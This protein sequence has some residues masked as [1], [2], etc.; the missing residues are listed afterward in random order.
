[1]ISFSLHC[2]A[3]GLLPMI[4]PQMLPILFLVFSTGNVIPFSFCIFLS[5]PF[6]TPRPIRSNA[7][8]S[9]DCFGLA[10]FWSSLDYGRYRNIYPPYSTFSV[11]LPLFP[12]RPGYLFPTTESV[13][14]LSRRILPATAHFCSR[15]CTN[16]R[17]FSHSELAE[18][19]PV[20]RDL[21]TPTVCS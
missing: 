11:A 20:K 10:H 8:P 19:K 2:V 18:E 13:T 15:K 17:P 6:N 16:R 21:R 9:P 12:V 1:V 5:R 7:T 3:T 14:P 4:S